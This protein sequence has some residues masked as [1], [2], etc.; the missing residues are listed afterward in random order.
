MKGEWIVLALFDTDNTLAPKIKKKLENEKILNI[1]TIDELINILNTDLSQ[2][3]KLLINTNLIKEAELNTKII[4][5]I[6]SPLKQSKVLFYEVGNITTIINGRLFKSTLT[7]SK[8]DSQSLNNNQDSESIS[9]LLSKLKNITSNKTNSKYKHIVVGVSTGG[10]VTLEKFLPLFPKDIDVSIVVIQHILR[11]NYIY[12]I[13]K[14]LNDISQI[15]VKVAEHG[16]VLQKGVAYFAP[17]GVH[18][19]YI[20]KP[21]GEVAVN[22]TPDYLKRGNSQLFDKDYKF[23]HI[24]SVDIGIESAS[25]IYKDQVIGV[26]LTGMGS[27]G[28]IALKYARDNGAYTFTEAES[29]SIIYG[30]PKVAFQKGGAI[31]VLKHYL[32]PNRILELI[33]YKNI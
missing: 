7:N 24:P 12:N 2:Y 17:P 25:D 13:C 1:N 10:P 30:M 20:T 11:G 18:L 27:D 29:T 32:I 16:E 4:P 9:D 14:R 8:S 26:I 6:N 3:T 33:N 31:E 23:I 28:A 5:L 21:N 22:L 15:T 19:S